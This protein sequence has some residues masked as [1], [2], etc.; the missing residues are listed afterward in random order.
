MKDFLE[1]M[2][3]RVFWISSNIAQGSFV[4]DS[5]ARYLK[6]KGVTHILNTSNVPNQVEASGYG[7]AEITWV[8]MRDHVLI[9]EDRAIAAISTLYRMLIV[10]GGT[11]FVHCVAGQN[12]SATVLWLF[13][14]AC[15]IDDS[16]AKR[17]IEEAN[18]D[19]VPAY[20]RLLSPDLIAKVK[21]YGQEHFVID[22]D[23]KALKPIETET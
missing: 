10:E 8:E 5:K 15:K 1:S 20:P 22:A 12:R 2:S 23:H 6:E 13:L 16:E 9:P 4:D 17:M 14:I 3:N 18:I 11:V 19:A 21:Q 7:F